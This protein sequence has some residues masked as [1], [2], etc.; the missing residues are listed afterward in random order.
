MPNHSNVEL[1]F[2]IN[3][4]SNE[5]KLKGFYYVKDKNKI[6][7]KSCN[8]KKITSIHCHNSCITL[9][10]TFP[11]GNIISTSNENQLLFMIF[12]LIFYKIFKMHMIIGLIILTL[13]MKIILLVVLMIKV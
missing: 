9:V 1:N 12:F 6:Q 3:I 8:L 4:I 11:S 7:L 10:S 2:Q 13:K 5:T